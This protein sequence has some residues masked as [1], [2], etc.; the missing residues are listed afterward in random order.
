LCRQPGAQSHGDGGLYLAG[1]LPP[2]VLPQL[3]DGAFLR[4][5]TAKGCFANLLRAV[6]VHV[7]T[8]NAASLGATIYGLDQAHERAA[9]LATSS[10]LPVALSANSLV[11]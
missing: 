6:P 4:A 2:R 7:I 5:F 8:V 3:Q 1:G 10:A 9:S 11:M